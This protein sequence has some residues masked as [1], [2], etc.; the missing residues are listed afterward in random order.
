M[1]P[2]PST[3]FDNSSMAWRGGRWVSE[4]GRTTKG[5]KHSKATKP[6]KSKKARKA[7]WPQ[8]RRERRAGTRRH[9]QWQ[10]DT[11]RN[12]ESRITCFTLLTRTF[13]LEPFLRFLAPLIASGSALSAPLRPNWLCSLSGLLGLAG[14]CGLRGLCELCDSAS[15][16]IANGHAMPAKR[17]AAPSPPR[18]ALQSVCGL[19]SCVARSS[20]ESPS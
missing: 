4:R 2:S 17:A 10:R 20:K 13:L 3:T 18:R 5:T 16:E 8:R 9:G 15:F 12:P 7:V 11:D 19:V 6:G 1:I 14:L